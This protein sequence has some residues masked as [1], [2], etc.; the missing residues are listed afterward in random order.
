MRVVAEGVETTEQKDTLLASGCSVAQGY[1]FSHPLP[2]GEVE[3]HF[4]GAPRK[5]KK[6]ARK[7]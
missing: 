3:I 2:V 1:L 7:R 4:G 5:A 6:A